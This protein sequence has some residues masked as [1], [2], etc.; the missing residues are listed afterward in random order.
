MNEEYTGKSHVRVFA[1]RSSDSLDEQ[2]NEEIVAG[3][4]E[5]SAVS[6]SVLDPSNIY[7]LV[8]FVT[9]D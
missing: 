4:Y 7:A 3:G 8:S 6:L 9:T 5:V 2:I 1:A